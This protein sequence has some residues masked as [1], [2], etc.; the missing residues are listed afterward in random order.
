MA[1]KNSIKSINHSYEP[2][3]ILDWTV[4]SFNISPMNKWLEN[5][6]T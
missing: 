2:N 6:L 1:K 5:N 4:D 3:S